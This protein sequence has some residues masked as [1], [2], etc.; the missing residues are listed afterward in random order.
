MDFY[1]WRY[2]RNSVYNEKIEFLSEL[3]RRITAVGAKVPV[4]ALLRV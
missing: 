1:I 4:D 2:I 3:R